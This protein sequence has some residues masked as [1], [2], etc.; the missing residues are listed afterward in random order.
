MPWHGHASRWWWA[1]LEECGPWHSA[2]V[3]A[4]VPLPE[5]LPLQRV[6][7]GPSAPRP[8]AHPVR[9]RPS[10]DDL[11]EAAAEGRS[12]IS[13]RPR[14]IVVGARL[15]VCTT[16]Q[17][18]MKFRS[19]RARP[20][21]RGG[22][23][24]RERNQRAKMPPAGKDEQSDALR[25]AARTNN[26]DKLKS[27]ISKGAD[28]NTAS[29]SMG[30]RSFTKPL[31]Y[32]GGCSQPRSCTCVCVLVCLTR[33]RSRRCDGPACTVIRKLRKCY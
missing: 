25:Q 21:N 32:G 14:P 12:N 30:D 20:R 1:Q 16:R 17:T 13:G 2:S 33:I 29:V 11:L 15:C 5:L 7:A 8:L 19:L 3:A 26:V 24:Q 9:S 4:P 31:R 18:N 6:H 23:R 28:V 27:L 10:C 22:G